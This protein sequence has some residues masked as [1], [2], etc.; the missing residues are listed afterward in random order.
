MKLSAVAHPNSSSEPRFARTSSP[1]RRMPRRTSGCSTVFSTTTNSA[2]STAETANAPSVRTDVQP[3]DGASTMAQTK[4]RK[5][6]VT[7]SAPATARPQEKEGNPPGPRRRAR[8][9]E[10]PAAAARRLIG[11]DDAHGGDQ[12]DERHRDDD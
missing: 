4:T 3:A 6:P 2:S 9:V 8:A 12:Q 1:E 11:P 5:P 7:V 10:A